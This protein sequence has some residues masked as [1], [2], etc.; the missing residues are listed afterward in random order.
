MGRELVLGLED[1]YAAGF[2]TSYEARQ[3]LVSLTLERC[4][5]ISGS[6]TRDNY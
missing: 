1:E 3:N 4:S 6:R 2:E 5:E